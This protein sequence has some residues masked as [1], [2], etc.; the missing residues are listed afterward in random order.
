MGMSMPLA[1]PVSSGKFGEMCVST[2]PALYMPRCPSQSLWLEAPSLP[3][4]LSFSSALRWQTALAL[5]LHC[6]A[7]VLASPCR[8][9]V[10]LSLPMVLF[11][12]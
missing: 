2:A 8:V 9:M 11:L 7:Q 5:R 12:A 1:V 6:A 4:Q 3:L 10:V